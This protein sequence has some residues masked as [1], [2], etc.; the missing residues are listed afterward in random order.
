MRKETKQKKQK[1]KEKNN[2]KKNEKYE[3]L[4]VSFHEKYRRNNE[5]LFSIKQHTTVSTELKSGLSCF[6]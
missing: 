6:K 2:V 3:S 1:R 5:M 4:S